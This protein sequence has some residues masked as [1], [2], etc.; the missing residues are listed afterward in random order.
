MRPCKFLAPIAGMIGLCGPLVGAAQEAAEDIAQAFKEGTVNVSFRYRYEYVDDDSP[1]LPDHT[2]NASTLRSRLS[3]RTAEYG[4]AGLLVEMDDLRTIGNDDYNSTRNG[5]TDRPTVADPEATDLNVAALRYMGLENAELVIGRQKISRGNE[6]FVGTVGWRQNEQTMDAASIGYGFGPKLQAYYAFVAQVNRI[7]GPEKA[8]P[9][10]PPPRYNGQ[11]HLA[12]LS[13]A[14]GPAA[15]LMVY[16]YLLDLDEAPTLS[17]Q[18]FGARLAGDI[19]LNEQWSVPYGVEFASQSEYAG[20][21]NDYDA[22]YYV[23]ELGLRRN[24]VSLKLVYEVLEGSDAPNEAFQTPLAT[25]HAFQGWVDKFLTTPTGGVEDAYVLVE[26]PL[27]GGNIRVRY[28]DYKAQTGS[29]DDYGSELGIWTTWPIGKH[30]AATVKYA[31]YGEDGFSSD[32]AKL[33][34]TLSANF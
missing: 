33:W 31:D 4:H 28:D 6:R 17:S 24:K 8:P 18:T 34:V 15:K 7:N 16:A 20:N 29:P 1:S 3:Y 21:P 14:F 12:D 26:F 32:T 30:Y 22:D 10:Q 5:K 19:A 9:G 11:T 2:A 25:G 13:Y 27:F 23:A